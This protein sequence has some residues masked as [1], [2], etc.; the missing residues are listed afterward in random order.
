MGNGTG[1]GFGDEGIEAIDEAEGPTDAEK[2]GQLRRDLAG[3]E[4]FD[5]AL[6]NAGFVGEVGL[7]KVAGEPGA[8]DS[9]A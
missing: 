7:S 6:G 2:A 3:F 4:T 9:R 1:G 8:R 5:G